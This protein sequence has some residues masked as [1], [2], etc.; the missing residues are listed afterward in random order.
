M[1]NFYEH[2]T[3]P[4]SHNPN[5]ELHG[6]QIPFRMLIAAPS[7]SGKTN[8]LM[9]LISV[10]NKTF[11]EI[12][13]CILSADEPLYQK[14]A[15]L[16]GVTFYEGGEVPEMSSSNTQKL[17]IFD[18]LVLH[19][20][21]NA[22]ALD[23]YI[24]G[25]KKKYSMCYLSQSYFQT[26][27]LIRINCQYLILGK[28]LLKKDLRLILSTIPSELTLDEFQSVYNKLTKAP[29]SVIVL[30][31][32]RRTLRNGIAGEI[33]SLTPDQALRCTDI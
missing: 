15:K 5:Y 22:K 7:G 27:K 30:D 2:C 17:I 19:K 21:A 16:R 28:N 26:P 3:G 33:M 12:H 23:Y 9:N 29:L 31:I 25:R 10:M 11:E 18:D 14:L 24:R 8:C 32:N 20:A 13:V 4:K 1:L 6:I